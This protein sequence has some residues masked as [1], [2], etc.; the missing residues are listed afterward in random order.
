M[1][2]DFVV[3]TEHS[4]RLEEKIESKAANSQELSEIKDIFYKPED[5][6]LA[7]FN[8]REVILRKRKF[9]DR[10]TKFKIK[11]V[12]KP[13][14]YTDTKEKI[15]SLEDYE[16]W[17]EFNS[18]AV[19]HELKIEKEK[20]KV[21]VEKFDFGKYIKIEAPSVETLDKVLEELELERSDIIEKNSAELLA[22]DM[23][24]I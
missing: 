9:P 14:G 2:E 16:K 4:P 19:E 23:N 3:R 8:P 21:L 7:D 18:F 1:E 6:E 12:K 10:E 11:I 17:G 5:L 20:I 15:Q 22:E 24:K 13:L